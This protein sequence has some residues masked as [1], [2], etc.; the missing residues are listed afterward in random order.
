M[1]AAKIVT[2]RDD[3]GTTYDDENVLRFTS[4]DDAANAVACN[5][6]DHTWDVFAP[7]GER[8]ARVHVDGG[9]DHITRKQELPAVTIECGTIE[10]GPW[11]GSLSII[12]GSPRADHFIGWELHAIPTLATLAKRAKTT[13]SR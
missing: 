8:V 9:I 6:Q 12:D 11:D 5:T 3:N 1:F 4:L 10:C 7:T 2:G 13:G